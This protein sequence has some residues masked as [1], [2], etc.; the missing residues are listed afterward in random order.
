MGTN[1][2]IQSD[3]IEP[4]DK[5]L[6]DSMGKIVWKR[7]SKGGMPRREMLK[8]LDDSI[9]EYDIFGKVVPHGTVVELNKRYIS[10][11]KLVVYLDENLHRGEGKILID[12][13]EA[14]K[15][16]PN[17]YASIYL[18]DYKNVCASSY[19][20][21]WIGKECFSFMYQ[22]LTDWRSNYG[23]VNI[24]YLGKNTIKNLSIKGH[25]IFALDFIKIWNDN[26]YCCK[27]GVFINHYI[28]FNISPGI[29]QEVFVKGQD[30]PIKFQD[31]ISSEKIAEII[32]I[33]LKSEK[34]KV[35]L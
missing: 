6:H 15:K 33:V 31:I 17:H 28:D 2:Y 22:S 26:G 21:L 18:N 27:G 9:E 16:Y 32:E 10:Y 19:R 24:I 5:Y 12:M 30:N 11:D 14:V 4:Y 20:H 8:F 29:P 35:S 34:N 23:H 13:K 25:S 1:I 7:L 3:F